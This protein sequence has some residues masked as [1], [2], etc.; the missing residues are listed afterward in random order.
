MIVLMNSGETA[1][2]RCNRPHN[3]SERAMASLNCTLLI[4][5][6]RTSVGRD[7]SLGQTSKALISILYNGDKEEGRFTAHLNKASLQVSLNI[8]DSKPC[9]SA[10]SV[11]QEHSAPKAPAGFTKTY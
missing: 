7:S 1:S 9:D 10:T 6:L 2:R 3:P 11:Q 4:L 8:R 5:F